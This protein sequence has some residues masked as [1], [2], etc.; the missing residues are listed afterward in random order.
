M[1]LQLY[2][3]EPPGKRCQENMCVVTD[4]K[5]K[6]GF[7]FEVV[8]KTREQKLKN[9]SLPLFP[10]IAIDGMIVAQDKVVSRDELEQFIA[11]H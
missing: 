1:L 3:N 10:A 4:L 11:A 7:D 2:V 8:K 6:Y 9:S 5:K